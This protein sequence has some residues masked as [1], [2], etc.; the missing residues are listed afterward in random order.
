MP[1][2]VTTRVLRAPSPGVPTPTRIRRPRVLRLASTRVASASS[3]ADPASALGVEYPASAPGEGVRGRGLF[4]TGDAPDVPVVRTPI[5]VTLCVPELVG[6]DAPAECAD[7]VRAMYKA[8]SASLDVDVPEP[9]VDFATPSA[10]RICAM[11]AALMWARRHVPRWRAYADDVM[12]TSYTSLYLATDEELEALQDEN[13]RRMAMG[14]KANYAAGWEMI[15]TQHPRVADAIDGSVDDQI[16]ATQEEFD[17][18]RATAHTRAMSG[19]VAGGPCA[20]IVPGVDL[21]NHHSAPNCEYGVSGDGGSFQ[22]TWDTTATREMPKAR[23]YPRA[24][25]RC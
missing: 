22:L 21:A 10:P 5:D 3:T 7:G 18:A 16:A 12:P 14:S 4:H 11:A 20:F 23:L 15:K 2:A 25:T 1:A 17:W 8:W 13:V 24:A 9:I 6:P 19:K